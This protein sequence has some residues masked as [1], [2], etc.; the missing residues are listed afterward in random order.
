MI[1]KTGYIARETQ[2][3]RILDLLKVRGEQGAFVYEFMT[4]KS[5]GG[6]GIAQYSARIWGLRH[7]GYVIDNPEKGKFVLVFEPG[8]TPNKQISVLQEIKEKEKEEK[9]DNKYEESVKKMKWMFDNNKGVA[10]QVEA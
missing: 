6:L 10:Y 2:E 4:P 8:L 1:K 9:E 5:K 7:K 3:G